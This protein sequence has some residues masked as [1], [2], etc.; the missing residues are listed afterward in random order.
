M[1]GEYVDLRIILYIRKGRKLYVSKVICQ[2]VK[3]CDW[4]TVA[5]ALR[6]LRQLHN[7]A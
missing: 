6:Q 5:G 7:K 1:S 3:E 2:W 4:M